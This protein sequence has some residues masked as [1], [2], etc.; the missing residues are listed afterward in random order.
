MPPV[1]PAARK[2]AVKREMLLFG[3]GAAPLCS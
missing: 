3:S 2:A 1:V